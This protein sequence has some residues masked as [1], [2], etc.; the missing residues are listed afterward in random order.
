MHASRHL[1]IR[2]AATA[3]ALLVGTATPVAPTAEP[4]AGR[5]PVTVALSLAPRSHSPLLLPPVSAGTD[6]ARFLRSH[7]FTVR[8]QSR[9]LVTATGT[10]TLARN[11]FGRPAS[12]ATTDTGPGRH[13]DVP[14]ALPAG[15][16]GVFGLDPTTRW[17]A[18][19][20]GGT[21][22]AVDL[23]SAYGVAKPITSAA[24]LTVATVQF[25]GWSRSDLATYAAATGV[26]MPQLTERTIGTAGAGVPDGSD[27][28]VEVALDHEAL[29]SAAP[30]AAHVIFFGENT[31]LGTVQ[32]YDAIATA[33]ERGEF[34]VLSISWGQCE[35]ALPPALLT[36]V[37]A[38]LGRVVAAGR[39]VFAA[40]GDDG[41]NGCLRADLRGRPA[42]D[43]PASSP[44]VVGVG[45]TSLAAA[46][47]G[48]WAE[49]AWKQPT[50]LGTASSGG[51]FSSVFPRPAWQPGTTANDP[52]GAK[53]R[54]VPD[55][56]AIADPRSGFGIFVASQGGWIPGGGTSLAAPTAA[57]HFAAAL[58]AAGKVNGLRTAFHP[59]LYANPQAVRDIVSGDNDGY[60]AVAGYDQVS[61]LGAPLWDRL[62]PVIATGPIVSIPPATRSLVVPVEIALPAG[63]QFTHFRVCESNDD[64]LCDTADVT[65][66]SAAGPYLLRLAPGPSRRA[67]IIVVGF[68][69]TGLQFPGA[70]YT[71]YDSTPPEVTS[72]A[73]LTSETAHTARFSWGAADPA[74]G[75]AVAGY[76]ARVTKSG[77]A[78]PVHSHRG[79]GTSW[80]ATLLPGSTYTLAVRASDTLGNVSRWTSAV[81]VVPV[82]QRLF[83]VS[84]GWRSAANPAAYGGTTITSSSRGAT[85]AMA[86]R[87]SGADLMFAAGPGGGLVDVY[88]GAAPVTRVDTYS[89]VPNARRVVRVATWAGPAPRVITLRVVGAR[90]PRSTGSAVTIDGL[91]VNW[92]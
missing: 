70:A 33:A 4:P 67:R 11:A 48:S 34:D 78:V 43:F 29:L 87:G 64:A 20:A 21:L 79:A 57:G 26:A 27:G 54:M 1:R 55:I 38:A 45:G 22:S 85:A 63:R 89:P 9:W 80:T 62:L 58:S 76:E 36:A 59:I 13:D 74:P 24:G 92:S 25:S 86:I 61:G 60:P 18:H 39:T 52:V 10:A 82:D 31:D 15:V 41:A 28:E 30:G 46:G 50:P 47:D 73:R 90:N 88:V 84:S 23:R 42:V 81:L 49:S 91:R 44:H 75:V 37:D 5:T 16:T 8:T 6:A 83:T 2:T 14:A 3:A 77:V 72:A 12:A 53:T 56:A 51:G 35:L 17:R 66:D 65:F 71:T 32:V 69:P 68:D 7:G 19:A 40:S